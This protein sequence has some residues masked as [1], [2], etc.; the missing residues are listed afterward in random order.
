[1]NNIGKIFKMNNNQMVMLERV[2]RV[3]HELHCKQCYFY[4]PSKSCVLTRAEMFKGMR[5]QFTKDIKTCKTFVDNV[6][7]PEC[8]DG[9]RITSVF[10]LLEGG[11]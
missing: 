7:V 10:K 6:T 11:V 9:D 4:K 8:Y 3:N 2:E 5:K 1:M